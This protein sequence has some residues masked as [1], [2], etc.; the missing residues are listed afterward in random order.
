[1]TETDLLQTPLDALHRQLGAKMVG[2][3]GYAMPVSYPLGVL[4]EH[5]HTR[6]AASVF[7]VSHMG[8]LMI[9][10]DDVIGAIEKLV[11]GDIAGLASHGTRYTL[12][13]NDQG[14]IRDD[15]MVSR[16]G[17]A[18]Y[19]VVNAACK[20]QDLAYLRASI[21]NQVEIE[22]LTDR[23]LLALQGPQAAEVLT[24]FS[25]AVQ[26]MNFMSVAEIHFHGTACL[27][28]RSGYTGEDGYEISIPADEAEDFAQLLLGE[29]EVTFAGLGA[30]DSLR[31]EAGLCLH[32]NDIDETTTPVEASLTW[33][34]GKSRRARGGFPGAPIILDQITNKPARKRVGILPEGRAPARAGTEITDMDGTPIGVVTSGGFGPTVGGPVAMG[35]VKTAFFSPDTPVQLMVRGKALPAKVARLPFTPHRYYAG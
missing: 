27:V 12:L 15:L 11:P 19:V 5:E 22:E 13:T 28:T 2:F 24:R 4:K 31:L 10:G 14:G 3:A 6:Q 35:Y 30:R 21:G 17:D 18:L 23:A 20:A 26:H 25:P 1:M 8:Q 9:R 7:D 16:L 34:I 32:G 29:P 33:V